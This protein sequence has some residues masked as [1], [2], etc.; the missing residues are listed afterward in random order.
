MSALVPFRSP[1]TIPF[2]ELNPLTNATQ[3]MIGQKGKIVKRMTNMFSPAVRTK[4]GVDY[5]VQHKEEEREEI[6]WEHPVAI[7]IMMVQDCTIISIYRKHQIVLF[8]LKKTHEYDKP[9]LFEV[10]NHKNFYNE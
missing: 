7:A 6:K 10:S 8:V 2:Q 4:E 9:L 1:L 3:I 5:S